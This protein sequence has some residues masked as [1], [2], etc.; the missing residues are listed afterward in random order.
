MRQFLLSLACGVLLLLA[1]AA[2]LDRLRPDEVEAS[3]QAAVI[4]MLAESPATT[5]IAT[6]RET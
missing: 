3:M 6:S 1:V 5:S 2:L 4:S